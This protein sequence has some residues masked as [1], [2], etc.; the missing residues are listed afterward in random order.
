MAKNTVAEIQ[1]DFVHNLARRGKRVD[2]RAFDGFRPISM[3]VN[4]IKTAEGSCRI[5]LGHSEIIV[6][7]KMSTGE[8]YPDH[9]EDG[10]IVTHVELAPLASPDFEIGPPR[11]E[12]IEL[13]RVVDRGIRE[14]KMIGLDSLCIEPGEKVWVVHIDINV[15]DNDGNLFDAATLG[16]LGSLAVTIVPAQRFGL[17]EDFPLPLHHIPIS[18]TFV[19]LGDK[20]AVDPSLEEQN[21][22]PA[23][24]TVTIDENGDIRAMQ[25]GI[26]GSFTQ[27]EILETLET[28]QRITPPLRDK[29]VSNTGLNMKK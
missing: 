7:I 17:G 16:V 20:M 13:A 4:P 15:L 12:A 25:K 6:G 18:S 27:E 24:L 9:R 26:G 1:R 2:D 28:A 29:V 19:K 22:A 14:S 10:V 21:V 5:K 11:E 3:E 23:R 8:P